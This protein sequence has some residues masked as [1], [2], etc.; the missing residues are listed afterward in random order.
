MVPFFD[1]FKIQEDGSLRWCEAAD[2]LEAAKTRISALAEAIPAQYMV[3][4]HENGQKLIIDG[5]ATAPQPGT[6]DRHTTRRPKYHICRVD[7]ENLRWVEQVEDL[8]AAELRVKT[9]KS[10]YPADY[11]VLDYDPQEDV[12]PPWVPL[13][14]ILAPCLIGSVALA[15]I[16]V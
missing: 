4:N 13:T 12:L 8:Q 3:V 14:C 10:A 1:I 16:F 2:N 11:L 9:L 6:I 5:S 7:N 15:S